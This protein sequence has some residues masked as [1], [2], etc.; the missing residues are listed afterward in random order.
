MSERRATVLLLLLN[1]LLLLASGWRMAQLRH[2]WAAERARL[3]LS[4][5]VE[6][7]VGP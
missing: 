4:L 5:S 7:P 6:P 1:G 3:E 2:A